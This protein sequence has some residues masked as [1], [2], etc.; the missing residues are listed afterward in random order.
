MPN[1]PTI[2][3]WGMIDTDSAVHE[4]KNPLYTRTMLASPTTPDVLDTMSRSWFAS[5][6]EDIGHCVNMGTLTPDDD[7]RP[8]PCTKFL[9]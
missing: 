5:Y 6:K 9:G 1:T 8:G 2:A 7:H 4:V 3:S